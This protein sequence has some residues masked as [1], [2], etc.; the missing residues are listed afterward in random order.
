[1]K[2]TDE[3]LR[4][5]A[6]PDTTVNNIASLIA[7][8]F[9]G[10]FSLSIVK[11]ASAQI[12]D[13]V[14]FGFIF[15]F[16]VLFLVYNE[17]IKVT[18]LRKWFVNKTGSL[19]LILCTFVITV[20]LSGI[21]IYFL[22]NHTQQTQITV[23]ATQATQNVKIEQRYNRVIDSLSNTVITNEPTYVQLKSDLQYWKSRT[24]VD[25]EERKQIREHVKDV[26][27]NLRQ[28]ETEFAKKKEEAI[29]RYKTQKI[30]EKNGVKTLYGNTLKAVS[31]S[32][33]ITLI[34]FIAVV[35][36]KFIIIL[37]SKQYTDARKRKQNI[38]SSQV[39]KNF[40]VQYKF[41]TE[42]LS[43]K[44]D[45]K[46][47]DIVFSP[48]FAF[49]KNKERRTKEVKAVYY[50]FGDLKILNAPLEEAQTKLKT[51]YEQIL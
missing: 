12:Q 32:N 38:L 19:F 13:P 16:T 8:F 23:D 5:D 33:V 6:L 45:I 2:I 31:K 40:F 24:A 37:L 20:C 34:F 49:S 17:Y 14:A 50:L 27:L 47:D 22:T 41:L 21:G 42:V 28:F 11:E 48:Y 25:L 15:L 1:M 43:R 46:F 10:I 9:S 30:V 29:L 39:A 7:S 44:S 18:E 35:L 51:Y 3:I 4:K 26:E 36:T